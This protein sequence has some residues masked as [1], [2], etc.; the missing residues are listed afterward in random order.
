MDG[1]GRVI[2]GG[3]RG[4]ITGATPAILERLSIGPEQFIR[5]TGGML[6]RFGS[7]I[8]TL[9]HLTERCVSRN[10][11]YLRGEVV[12]LASLRNLAGEGDF[13]S[14]SSRDPSS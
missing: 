9:E 2:R 8:G 13:S 6:H 12:D 11:A 4:L 5:T 14:T 1:T 7:A 3:K 10:V